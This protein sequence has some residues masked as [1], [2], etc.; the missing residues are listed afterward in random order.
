MRLTI[1]LFVI[2]RRTTSTVA[3]QA[4]MLHS[5][6]LIM[7]FKTHKKDFYIFFRCNRFVVGRI[8]ALYPIH[9]PLSVEIGH[10]SHL[11]GN[12]RS[13]AGVLPSESACKCVECASYSGLCQCVHDW[14]HVSLP[15]SRR[16]PRRSIFCTRWFCRFFV[17]RFSHLHHSLNSQRRRKMCV[18]H[19][20][21]MVSSCVGEMRILCIF[22][23]PEN[24]THQ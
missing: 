18:S 5:F 23:E 16:N 22:M 12:R 10:K 24:E 7:G 21:Q 3:L 1:T 4:T 17:F 13:E 8:F 19:E 9:T 2:S 20:C 14:H 15:K 6:Q 11:Q